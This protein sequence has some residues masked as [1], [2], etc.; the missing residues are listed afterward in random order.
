MG[1]ESP[2]TVIDRLWTEPV[3]VSLPGRQVLVLRA[4][5]AAGQTQSMYALIA[6][7]VAKQ[8]S[9]RENAAATHLHRW[10]DVRAPRGQEAPR[11]A[12]FG[13]VGAGAAARQVAM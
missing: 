3:T 7:A 10:V 6:E 12:S 5:V 11:P 2:A 1:S 8:V 4:M 13:V 9:D